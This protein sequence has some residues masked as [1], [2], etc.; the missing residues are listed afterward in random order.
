[1][2]VFSESTTLRPAVC[3][4]G[5]GQNQGEPGP[6]ARRRAR[7][8]RSR[9]AEGARRT[10]IVSTHLGRASPRRRLRADRYLL[11]LDA[12]FMSKV[13]SLSARTLRAARAPAAGGARG[14]LGAGE[15]PWKDW[16]VRHG[17]RNQPP[18]F[19]PKR[20]A[21][22]WTRVGGLRGGHTAGRRRARVPRN[23]PPRARPRFARDAARIARRARFPSAPFR[24]SAKRISAGGKAS[25]I[26]E[27]MA[28]DTVTYRARGER[29]SLH[30]AVHCATTCVVCG[31]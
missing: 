23:S 6:V 8:G 5:G 12:D 24:R 17:E 9:A 29:G 25:K 19:L 14:H 30:D 26:D 13:R 20:R 21:R 3:G 2:P 15:G 4:G 27:R 11:D 16:K 31:R 1:M 10:V 28:P 22:R 7:E 18:H